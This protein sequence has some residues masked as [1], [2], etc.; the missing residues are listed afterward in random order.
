M[1]DKATEAK[2]EEL[3]FEMSALARF[4]ITHGDKLKQ[5]ENEYLLIIETAKREAADKEA[6]NEQAFFKAELETTN[7][8][9]EAYAVSEEEAKDVLSI[10]WA[11][12][13]EATGATYSWSDLEEDVY[14][15]QIV[16]GRAYR[17]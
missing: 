5:L 14:V 12:H 2:L 8:R 9:F 13:V 1:F 16:I 11:N 3:H 6:K 10:A 7:F 4:P 15:S 17:S